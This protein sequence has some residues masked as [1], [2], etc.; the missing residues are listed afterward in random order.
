MGLRSTER[1][2][3]IASCLSDKIELT[4]QEKLAL[5]NYGFQMRE[6]GNLN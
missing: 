5:E 6:Q 4:D 3:R 2:G 1:F